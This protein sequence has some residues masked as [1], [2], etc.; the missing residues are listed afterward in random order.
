VVARAAEE[1]ATRVG[2]R[3]T[4]DLQPGIETTPAAREALRRIVREATVNATEHGQAT[5]L[6]ISLERNGAGLHLA[7]AD[8]GSGF[9]PARPTEGFGLIS[10]HE[11]AAMLGGEAR[12]D[13]RPGAGTTVEV[14]LR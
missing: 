2:A 9:D 8:D 1:V 4:L 14:F 10:I 5:H 7:I 12:I 11:R 3:L 6:R 13:S